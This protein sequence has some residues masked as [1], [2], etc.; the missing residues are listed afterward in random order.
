MKPLHGIRA[1]L[2]DLDGTLIDSESLTDRAVLDLLQSHSIASD[3]LDLIQFHGL[4]WQGIDAQLRAL[5]PILEQ[6]NHLAD[7]LAARCAQLAQRQPPPFIPGAQ[8]AF[9]AASD[10]LPT[11]IV[12][13]SN[14]AT[15]E[16]VLQRADLQNA[17]SFYVSSEHYTGSKPDPACY[18]LAADRLGLAPDTCLVFEDSMPGLHA[19]RSAGMPAIAVTHSTSAPPPGLAARC[20]ADYT[21]LADDFFAQISV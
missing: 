10:L 11:A 15:V 21:E 8:R 20:I 18:Q 13:G 3:G 6:V 4:S 5:F 16:D 17:C 2:F 9:L 1:V 14:A 7:T 19:A 12:T